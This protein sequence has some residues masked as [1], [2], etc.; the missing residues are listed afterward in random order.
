MQCFALSY[1][2]SILDPVRLVRCCAEARLAV[3]LIFGVVSV[4]EDRLAL[5]LK[6]EDVRGDPVEKP[7]VVA[8]DH[9]TTRKILERLLERAYR[10]H[11][12]I[13]RGLV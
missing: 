9:G 1:E 12:Q 4:E 5:P 8:D 7:A 3:R 11:V 2:M 6:R 10:V 13:V